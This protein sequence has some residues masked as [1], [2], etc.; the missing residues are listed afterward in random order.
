MF[1]LQKLLFCTDGGREAIWRD[2]RTWSSPDEPCGPFWVPFVGAVRE[3]Y[4]KPEEAP[5]DGVVHVVDANDASLLVIHVEGAP[6]EIPE[7]EV[8]S[9]VFF[10]VRGLS[11]LDS[12]PWANKTYLFWARVKDAPGGRRFDRLEVEAQN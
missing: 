3:F 9:D 7:L 10:A 1:Y 8:G 11:G 4:R 6:D 5:D 2:V 12:D